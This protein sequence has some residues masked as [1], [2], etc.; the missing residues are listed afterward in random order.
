MKRIG[1]IGGL[2]PESTVHYYQILCREYNRRVG[3]LNFPE[4]TIESLNLQSL[5]TLFEKNNWEGVAAILLT[6]LSRLHEAG[7]DFA[8]ILANTP[9]N[10]YDQIRDAAPLPILT[11]M[12]AT[13]AALKKDHRQKVALLGTKPTMEFGFFQKTFAAM[14]IETCVPDA[15]QRTELDRIVWEELSYGI[16]EPASRNAMKQMIDD[17]EKQGVEAVILGC[18]ELSLLIRESDTRL[19]LY[20]TTQ[21]HAEAI[22]EF[23][24]QEPRAKDS[25]SAELF[26]PVCYMPDFSEEPQNSGSQDL[27]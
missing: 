6:A 13:A 26:S 22:L 18:T 21:I 27:S 23:A 3:G 7:A 10:A 1:L 9:H 14:G 12:D 25:P 15:A 17:L 24:M 19:P 5:V 20:D 8:A 11:I 16:L 2:S 4:I